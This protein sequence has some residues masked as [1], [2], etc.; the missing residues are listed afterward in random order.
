[1][2]IRCA[3]NSFTP[4]DIAQWKPAVIF[5]GSGMDETGTS[6]GKNVF[7]GKC[8]CRFALRGDNKITGCPPPF[9]YVANKL[10]RALMP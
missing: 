8:A 9:S 2:A 6:G 7:I 3:L 4:Q 1:V 5:V 10:T